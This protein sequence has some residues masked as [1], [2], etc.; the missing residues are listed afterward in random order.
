[1]ILLNIVLEDFKLEVEFQGCTYKNKKVFKSESIVY[2][3][4]RLLKEQED[5]SF[6]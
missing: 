1:M 5:P 3:L 4:F 6:Y 2:E